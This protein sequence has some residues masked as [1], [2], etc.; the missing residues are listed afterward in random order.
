MRK[1][2][3][4]VI[5]AGDFN[6]QVGRLSSSERNIGGRFSLDTRRTNNGERLL[7]FCSK[8]NLYLVSTNHRHKKTHQAT[9]K[10]ADPHHTLT[11]IDH[12]A[13]SY[14]WRGSVQ[15][16]RS[17]W[18]TPLDSDHAL[19]LARFVLQF[20]GSKHII[21]HRIDTHKLNDY[22]IRENYQRKISEKLAAERSNNAN[23]QWDTIR[24]AIKLTEPNCC[25][26][27]SI[28]L[29]TR[30]VLVTY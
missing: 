29:K 17:F 28:L 16:C 30:N 10:S 14:R 8:H 1:A 7:D 23:E 12:I 24:D 15:N 25:S 2:S 26:V 5:V 19:V 20:S 9:W 6:A 22:G 27:H 18:S 21:K 13:V 4:I 11:Q 3:D